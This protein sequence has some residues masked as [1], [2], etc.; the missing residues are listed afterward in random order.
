[1]VSIAERALSIH[2]SDKPTKSATRIDIDKV[3]AQNLRSVIVSMKDSF[4]INTCRGRLI[5]Q[6]NN[7]VTAAIKIDS[8]TNSLSTLFER[9]YH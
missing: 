5:V 7:M 3:D 4:R 1:V 8:T 9:I 6:I 2:E